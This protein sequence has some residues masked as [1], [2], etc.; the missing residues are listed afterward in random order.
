MKIWQIKKNLNTNPTTISSKNSN[1]F[2][3]KQLVNHAIYGQGTICVIEEK[4]NG[5]YVTVQFKNGIKKIL[6]SFLSKE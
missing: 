6:S 4:I 2:H 3:I 1:G 5:T